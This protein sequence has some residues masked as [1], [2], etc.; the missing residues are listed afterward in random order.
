ML[1]LA[2]EIQN[3]LVMKNQN[4]FWLTELSKYE[5]NPQDALNLLT[6]FESNRKH[7]E[8]MNLYFPASSLSPE[9][10][11]KRTANKV[12]FNLPKIAEK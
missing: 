2:K 8:M 1:K 9:E 3:Q 5:R 10:K 12:G 7:H 4:S 6:Y 11:I